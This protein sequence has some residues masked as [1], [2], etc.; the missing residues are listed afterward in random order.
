[1]G[2]VVHEWCVGEAAVLFS[3]LPFIYWVAGLGS[4]HVA[5]VECGCDQSVVRH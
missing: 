3:L 2:L 1:V 4:Y 5:S